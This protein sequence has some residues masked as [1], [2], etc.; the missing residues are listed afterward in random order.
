M[1]HYH[2]SDDLKI[3]GELKTLAPVEFGAFVA[4]DNQVGRDDGAIPRKYRE[5]IAL[6]VACTTQCPYCAM[7]THATPRERE[8]PERRSRKPPSSP[9]H[10]VPVPP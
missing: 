10:Y 5:L 9:P 6:A 2:D 8:R 4:L 3:L 7:Y 1:S